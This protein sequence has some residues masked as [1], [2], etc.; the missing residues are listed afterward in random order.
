LL[1]LLGIDKDALSQSR[2]L[3]R[4]MTRVCASCHQKRKCDRDLSAR[5][6]AQHYEQYCLSAP[7]MEEL[8]M[9]AG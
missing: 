4:D 5:S 9:A 3:S 2:L 1:T 7:V 8:K 6:S